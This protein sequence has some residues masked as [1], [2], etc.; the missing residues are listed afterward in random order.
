M[1]K[2]NTWILMTLF[3]VVLGAAILIQKT[4]VL[5][6]SS[7]PTATLIPPLLDFGNNDPVTAVRLVDQH[8]LD[9]VSKLDSTNQWTIAQ[10]GGLQISQGSMQMILSDLNG[11]AVQSTLTSPL[12]L[13]STGLQLPMYTIS[14]SYQSGQSH[15]VKVG[16]L[17]PTQS[18]YYVQLD[19]GN[20]VIVNQ[21][22][23]DNIVEL[24][25]SVTYTPTPS[26]PTITTT[27][28][29]SPAA[30]MTPITTLTPTP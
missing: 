17:T 5:K 2:R 14:I 11:I 23:I 26:Q 15:V 16:N 8:G 4:N 28:Q 1:I 21:S 19:T 30:S 12:P 25:R 10:P 13:E 24:L 3:I 9:I 20:T 27:L 22:G 6:P 7:T 18:G 29:A